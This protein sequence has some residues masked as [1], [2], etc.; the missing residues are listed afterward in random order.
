MSALRQTPFGREFRQGRRVA[1]AG[2]TTSALLAT[3]NII[4]GMVTQSRSVF[5]TGV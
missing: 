3:L 4:V 5:A 1:I 2:I